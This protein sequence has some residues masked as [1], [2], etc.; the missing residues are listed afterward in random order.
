MILDSPSVPYYGMDRRTH[1]DRAF[2]EEALLDVARSDEFILKRRVAAF[3]EE[4][5]RYSGAGGAV[6]VASGTHALEVALTALGVGPGVEV[7]VPAFGFHSSASA[8][9]R[10][11]GKPVLVDV[12]PETWHLDPDR[13][14]DA[15]GESTAGVVPVHL[16]TQ[17]ADMPA[18]VALAREHDAWVLENSAVAIGMRRDGR[19]A[20]LF[21][22]I[23]LYSF[24]PVK[25]IGG[26]SDG[27]AIVGDDEELIRRCRMLRNH[28]QDG[29]TRFLHHIVGFNARMDEV[30]GALLS[31]RLA[32]YDE[33]IARRAE[34]AARYDEAL[35]DLAPDL[36]VPPPAD[37]EQ[38]FY[39]YTVACRDRDGLERHLAERGIE[40]KVYYPLPLHLQPAFA[41]LGH[42]E[43]DFPNA[44]RACRES[45]ALPLYPDMPDAD[46]EAT[47]AAVLEHHGR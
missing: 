13:L 25:P 27:A 33:S 28:G 2:I 23:G 12:D 31:R 30:T 3:E 18:I 20:G 15:I 36:R 8:V 21:G 37:H 26:A 6:A 46:V 19:M 47:I 1:P 35:A 29:I 14:A 10:R 7:I 16:F 17:M 11:G 24:Q 4:L 42:G 38:V 22:D 40:T 5:C 44:E 32:R 34:I 9:A 39:T 43:G 41:W 45:L